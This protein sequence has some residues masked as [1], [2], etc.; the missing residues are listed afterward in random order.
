MP[1][2]T[3][4]SDQSS[5]P[6]RVNVF[7]DG[8]FCCGIRKRTFQGM[9]LSPGD[10]ITCEELKGKE[11]FYWKQSYGEAAWKKEKVRIDKVKNLIGVIDNHLLVKVVGFGADTLELIEKHPDEKGKPDLDI[12]TN[13]NPDVVL[14][15]VEVTGTERLRGT[16]YWVRPDKLE[17]AE[18][19]PDEDVWIV[20]ALCR[21]TGTICFY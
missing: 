3:E 20:F 1:K 21:T 6:G 8:Q 12:S 9:N 19:H 4:I 7:I 15:K 5:N 18:N 2:I 16:G 10:E 14:L 17:Y 13:E 11:N